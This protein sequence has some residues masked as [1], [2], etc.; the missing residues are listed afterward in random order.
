MYSMKGVYLLFLEL[1]EDREIEIGALGQ[2]NFSKG[3]YVYVG[4]AQNSVEKRLQRHFSTDKKLHWHIDY[5]L[6]ESRPYDYFILPEKSEY[7]QVMA[8]IM[9]EIA[10]PV[11]EFGASD[12]SK[13]S[14]LFRL[15]KS[16]T[17]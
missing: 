7:E 5:L 6:E 3:K 16:L 10:E 12:S 2:I 8:S 14:H 1:E 4:S 13:N 9:E 15:P 17:E 11:P